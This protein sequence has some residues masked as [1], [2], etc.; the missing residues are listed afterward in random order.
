MGGTP[1]DE[2]V[3]DVLMRDLVGHDRSPSSYLVYLK[4]WQLT[5]GPGRKP[6]SISLSRLAD[7]TGLSKSSVQTALRRLKR[8]GLIAARRTAPVAIPA[9]SVIAPWRR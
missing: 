3:F 6:A 8:R 2:Y 4:L 9:Y 1:V 5:G 7:E